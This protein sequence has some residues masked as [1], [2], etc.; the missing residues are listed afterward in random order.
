MSDKVTCLGFEPTRLSEVVVT[1]WDPVAQINES[2]AVTLVNMSA[3]E[4]DWIFR[5]HS[6][7]SIDLDSEPKLV[8]LS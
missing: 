8:L 7:V 3:D 5:T 1:L 6:D 2:R 4:S